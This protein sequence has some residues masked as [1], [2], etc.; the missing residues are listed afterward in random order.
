MRARF[1]FCAATLALA[2]LALGCAS[3]GAGAAR[4]ASGDLMVIANRPSNL[5]LVDLAA[6]RIVRTCALPAAPTPGTIVL[7]PDRR[8]AYVLGGGMA[9]IYGVALESC[10]LVFSTQ[11][12]LGDERVRTLGGLT[13]SPDG[14]RLFVYQAPVKLFTDHYEVQPTRIAVFDTAAGKA[15]TALRTLAA[16]R[17]V[18]IMNTVADGTLILGGPDIYAMDPESGAVRV[19]LPSRSRVDPAFGPR[20]V[21]TVWNIGEAS[22]E[23]VRM[24]SA[25]RWKPGAPGD[26][27]Q[28]DLVWGYER[29]DL[30]SGVASDAVVGPLENGLFT[31]MTRPGR[32]EQFY[33]VLTQLQRF[34]VP[35][36][37]IVQSVDLEHSY[38]ALDF[39]SDGE[40]LYL[41]GTFNDVAIYDADTLAKLGNIVL[42][43]GDMATGGPKIF[44]RN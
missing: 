27:A 22:G 37:R 32:P 3:G 23:F 5:H 41:S 17:Q 7:S 25:A 16:P 18:T 15:A 9:E 30:A 21:L 44:R 1:R 28:A 19:L 36:Q 10:E 12:S 2:A 14:K 40:T 13:L 43:G 34:D 31:G 35:S 6:R 20:D 29:V 26:A 42:P 33:A 4:E 8:V 39:G 38:Y 24:F 11:Q